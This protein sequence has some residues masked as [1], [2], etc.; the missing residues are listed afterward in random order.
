MAEHGNDDGVILKVEALPSMRRCRFD[1]RAVSLNVEFPAAYSFI[2]AI[3]TTECYNILS[4]HSDS[5][6]PAG[7]EVK[8]T[9][10]R[11]NPDISYLQQRPAPVM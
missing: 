10:M 9:L 7:A 1:E 6:F 2:C 3:V 4:T 5:V 11:A 8:F